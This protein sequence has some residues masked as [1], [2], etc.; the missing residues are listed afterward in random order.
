MLS[1]KV[2]LISGA[3]GALGSAVTREFSQTQ[4][5]LVLTGRSERKL[6][7]LAGLHPRYA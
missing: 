6:E 7:R 5:H 4:A 1:D 3:T 2:V